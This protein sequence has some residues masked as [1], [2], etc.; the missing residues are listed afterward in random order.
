M[1]DLHS[2]VLFEIDDGAQSIEASVEILK[3]AKDAKINKMMATPHFTIGEDVDMFLER[4]NRRLA[5]L[6][7]AIEEQGLDI[8]L[9]GG[10]EV[11]ITDEI[12]N[13]DKLNLLTFEDNNIMLTEFKYHSLKPEI[14][15]DYV[16]EIQK[17]GVRILSSAAVDLMRKN[18]LNDSQLATFRM[19]KHHMG[20]GYACG[21]RT[22]MNSAEGGNLM[23]EGE[24][25]WDGA[26]LSY[27]SA[28]PE[29]RISI[30]H[31][32]HMGFH[33]QSVIPRLRNVIYSCLD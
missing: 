2:H 27:L 33:H 3:R 11:Y 17:N 18:L 5:A 10:A 7:V 22:N 26:K 25:G 28:C 15:L 21:V 20:Y 4:R 12:F 6:K 23:P 30:F 32:D 24:F 31:A 14:F 19:S 29:S 1:V 16:D 8:R 9:K 13:E